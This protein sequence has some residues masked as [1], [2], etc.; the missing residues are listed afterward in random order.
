LGGHDLIAHGVPKGNIYKVLLDRV[1]AA[2]LD[3]EVR[4]RDEALTLVDRLQRDA[5][6]A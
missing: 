3:G 4:T 5:D 6:P 1:R 2:Q